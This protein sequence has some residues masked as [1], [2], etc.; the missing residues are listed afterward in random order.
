[1]LVRCGLLA[2]ALSLLPFVTAARDTEKIDKLLSPFTPAEQT[3]IRNACAGTAAAGPKSFEE[4]IRTKATALKE[5]PGPPN[6]STLA[7][8]LAE[9][10]VNACRD[11]SLAGPASYYDCLQDKAVELRQSP[12][13]PDITTFSSDDQAAMRNACRAAES[14]GPAR[15]YACLRAQIAEL[16]RAPARPDLAAFSPADQAAMR[17]A[18]AQANLSGA[19]NFYECVRVQA[20]EFRS[21]GTVSPRTGALSTGSSVPP[22]SPSTT[23]PTPPPVRDPPASHVEAPAAIVPPTLREDSSRWWLWIAGL[24]GLAAWPVARLLSKAGTNACSVCNATMSSAGDVCDA[25][26]RK[27]AADRRRR[28]QDAAEARFREQAARERRRAQ[29][30]SSTLDPHGVLGVPRDATLEQIKAA[31]RTLI[32][33]YHPDKVAQ[34]GPELRQLAAEKSRQINDAYQMLERQGR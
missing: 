1:M 20:A 17:E 28:E 4:C 2:G 16:R 10:I 19:A 34:L 24:L 25:C 13:R 15:L 32:V 6:L 29:E 14:A 27:A 5:S 22:R 30:A 18:C 21:R 33:Q 3:S 26:T 11:A 7:P 23:R 12:G 8:G 9:A 31:Y